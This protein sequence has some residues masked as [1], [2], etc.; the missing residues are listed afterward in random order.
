MH[1]LV[2]DNPSALLLLPAAV[3]AMLFFRR[4]SS[5]TSRGRYLV[6]GLRVL[7]LLLVILALALP[8]LVKISRQNAPFSV[9]VLRD[10]S[11]SMR[12]DAP[13]RDAMLDELLAGLGQGTVDVMDFAV[14]A[15]PRGKPLDSSRTNLQAALELLFARTSSG[16]STQVIVLSDGRENQGN[17]AQ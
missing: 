9:T 6:A 3:L 2:L 4:R 13:Q 14:G 8:T 5:L 12:S 7:A 17:A 1:H 15:V 16:P 10:V 11:D